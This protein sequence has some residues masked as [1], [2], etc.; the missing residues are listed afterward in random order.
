MGDYEY[1]N[2]LVGYTV[3][4][5]DGRKYLI[6]SSDRIDRDYFLAAST[7]PPAEIV[8]FEA[9]IDNDQIKAGKI[10]AGKYEGRNYDDIC[11]HL[12]DKVAERVLNTGHKG[13]NADL[14]ECDETEETPADT[15]ECAVA[16]SITSLQRA[17]S[18]EITTSM[19]KA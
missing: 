3:K 5:D 6:L 14:T 15:R 9:N 19:D 1:V 18:V 12:W 13:H 8:V 10:E 16:Q 2:K 7:S 11:Q 4:L 17:T